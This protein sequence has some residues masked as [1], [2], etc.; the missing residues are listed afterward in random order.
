MEDIRNKLLLQLTG[1]EFVDLLCEGLGLSAL[2][3][4]SKELVERK[5]LVYGLK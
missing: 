1:Q 3:Y 5:H 4:D 2:G